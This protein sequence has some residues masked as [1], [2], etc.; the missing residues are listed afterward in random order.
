MENLK[1]LLVNVEVVAKEKG[2]EEDQVISA[3]CEGIETAVRKNFP[4]G[5]LLHVDFDPESHDL[6]AWR[7]Y[8]LVNQIENPEAEMLFNEIEDEVVVDDYVWESFE[9]KLNRQQFNI[10]KQVAL[11]KIKSD[12]RNQ[13][14]E[15][16]LNKP[17][18]LFSGTVKVMRRDSVIV[19]C[20]GL[21]ITIPRANMLPEDNYKNGD[22]I[23]FSLTKEKNHY[24]GTR[25]SDEYLKEVFKR[26]IV[27]V[28]EG[29]I[30][31]VRCARTPGVRAKVLVQ[32]HRPNVDAV[33]T[34]IGVRGTHIKNINS[35]MNKEVVDII[36]YDDNVANLLTNA[37]APINVTSILIDEDNHSI[38]IAV[39]DDEIAKAIGKGGKNI[40]LVSKIVDWNIN[41]YSNSDWEEKNSNENYALVKM[42][43]Q[44]LNCDDELAQHLVE[45]G[46]MSF[47]EVAYVPLKE[48]EDT[49]L[50]EET[51][52]ALKANASEL[53]ADKESLKKALGLSYLIKNGLTDEEIEKLHQENV[54]DEK[55]VGELSTYDFADILPEFDTNKAKDMIMK[56]REK[57][58]SH[59]D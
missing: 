8:K 39:N 23:F 17:V 27:Q 9:L 16:L 33:K 26:E 24:V 40:E 51:I 55:D 6:K 21:D 44:G 52:S 19:D 18:Q 20:N 36:K 59:A 38:D 45:N 54:F 13:Q 49:G 43:A 37:I 42:F 25:T 4:E 48:F 31:I 2:I 58:E 50:D 53:L 22:K 5:S 30:E 1:E 11:Q 28:E 57:E 35:F 41:V 12:S 3:I 32:S 7:L 56:A 15:D 10:T 46:F 14:I 47:E 34:C 29:D